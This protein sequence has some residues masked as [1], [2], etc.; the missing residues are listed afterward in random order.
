MST[1]FKAADVDVED[2]I[3]GVSYLQADVTIY[4]NPALLAEYNPL[5]NKIEALEEEREELAAPDQDTE[6]TDTSLDGKTTTTRVLAGERSMRE[7]AA[8]D[9][10]VAQI[11]EELVPLYERAEELHR[12]FTND[13]EVW[14]LR[15]VEPAEA[16]RVREELGGVPTEPT[17]LAKNA[18][19]TMRAKHVEELQAW[20]DEMKAFSLEFTL[21]AL[22]FS[23]LKVVVNGKE[24]PPPTIEQLRQIMARPGGPSHIDELA[25]AMDSLTAEGVNIVA[26]HRS[27]A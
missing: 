11:D 9:P 6:V 8:E 24:V 19:K 1:E 27:R 2:W 14:T 10:R 15:K 4:R 7:K 25:K 21:N 5:L 16:D 17:P 13:T 12:R 3:N 23:V 26:P 20:Y 22:A 18:S